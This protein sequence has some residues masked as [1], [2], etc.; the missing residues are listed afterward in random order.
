MHISP[1]V[2]DMLYTS[3]PSVRPLAIAI[4]IKACITTLACPPL[5]KLQGS[6]HVEIFPSTLITI[7]QLPCVPLNKSLLNISSSLDFRAVWL[8]FTMVMQKVPQVVRFVYVFPTWWRR[9]A[10]Q[11]LAL[12]SKEIR[13]AYDAIY[14]PLLELHQ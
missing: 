12:K 14:G 9:R 4:G 8:Y 13:G 11:I 3:S 1:S 2:T 7:T 6:A 10:C 5:E